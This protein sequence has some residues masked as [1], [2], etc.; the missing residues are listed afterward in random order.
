VNPGIRGGDKFA[1]GSRAADTGKTSTGEGR[2]G[3][4]V[5]FH[6]REGGR[7]GSSKG[8]GWAILRIVRSPLS[9]YRVVCISACRRWPH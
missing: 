8:V 7:D 5:G 9:L 1:F 6:G 4:E 2:S 3:V